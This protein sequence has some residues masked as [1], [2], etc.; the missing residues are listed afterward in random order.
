MRI[1]RSLAR[2]EKEIAGPIALRKTERFVRIRVDPDALDFHVLC[3]LLSVFEQAGVKDTGHHELSVNHCATLLQ[4]VPC[5]AENAWITLPLI[6]EFCIS[7]RCIFAISAARAGACGSDQ[8]VRAVFV[9]EKRNLKLLTGFFRS[10][11]EK[12]NFA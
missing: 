4:V 6:D 9:L 3:F 2:D 7:V 5:F 11:R 8:G 12:Q 10:L 1:D